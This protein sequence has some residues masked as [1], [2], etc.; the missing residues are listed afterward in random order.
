MWTDHGS[1]KEA[2]RMEM[3]SKLSNNKL[4]IN[5]RQELFGG[6]F[7]NYLLLLTIP[8]SLGLQYT[9]QLVMV[10]YLL[11]WTIHHFLNVKS[12]INIAWL[13]CWRCKLNLIPAQINKGSLVIS[14]VFHLHC[15]LVIQF[16]IT[17]FSKLVQWLKGVTR[18]LKWLN[19]N[20]DNHFNWKVVFLSGGI[21]FVANKVST[22]KE[23]A[24]SGSGVKIILQMC[25]CR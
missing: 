4:S 12:I 6:I 10:L 22:P 21:P 19:C 23:Y 2:M 9:P 24:I 8:N 5:R 7:Y 13:C 17:K 18:S 14:N 15:G 25:H 11:V 16:L 3:R 1:V 20:F